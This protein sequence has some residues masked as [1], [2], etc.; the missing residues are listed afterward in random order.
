M[1]VTTKEI[2]LHIHGNASSYAQSK[3]ET[4]TKVTRNLMT[5]TKK[6][7]SLL[8]IQLE[9]SAGRCSTYYICSPKEGVL[10]HMPSFWPFLA[11]FD[12]IC[13]LAVQV[14]NGGVNIHVISGSVTQVSS[15]GVIGIRR[16]IHV[17]NG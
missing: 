8:N 15:G 5:C 10:L 14:R 11:F 7:E 16:V 12:V 2:F 1:S 6:Y 17:W 9:N 4:A 3:Q 13:T